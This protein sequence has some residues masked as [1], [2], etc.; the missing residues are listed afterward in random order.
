MNVCQ[1]SLLPL[2]LLNTEKKRKYMSNQKSN[3]RDLVGMLL[4]LCDNSSDH[5]SK[6]EQ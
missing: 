3:K 4:F 5:A 6:T 2:H 1:K